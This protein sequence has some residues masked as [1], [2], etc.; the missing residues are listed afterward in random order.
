[1]TAPVVA[2]VAVTV[3]WSMDTLGAEEYP[4]PPLVRVTPER[5]RVSVPLVGVMDPLEPPPAMAIVGSLVYPLPALEI[6]V[7]LM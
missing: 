6:L 3:P 4:D 5:L 1:M 7:D 2:R